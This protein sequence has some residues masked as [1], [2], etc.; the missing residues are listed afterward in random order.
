MK[1]RERTG[2]LDVMC[3][4]SGGGDA[5]ESLAGASD[6]CEVCVVGA[7]EASIACRLS[8]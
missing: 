7:V 1:T 4:V 2:W 5:I 6:Y 8:I 3:V